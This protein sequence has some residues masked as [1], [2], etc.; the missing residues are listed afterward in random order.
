MSAFSDHIKEVVKLTLGSLNEEQDGIDFLQYRHPDLPLLVGFVQ[1]GPLNENGKIIARV[2]VPYHEG[3]KRCSY[4]LHHY[5]KGFRIPKR[6]IR[7]DRYLSQPERVSAEIQANVINPAIP[8]A[9]K[10]TKALADAYAVSQDQRNTAQQIC[11]ILG[12]A[13]PSQNSSSETVY[14]DLFGVSDHGYGQFQIRDSGY[15]E[16]TM[17]S[18]SSALAVDLARAFQQVRKK[19]DKR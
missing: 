9:I 19:H 3:P 2:S 10:A 6:A 11:K 7:A 1:Q 13:N 5:M 17:Q 4:L 18:L 12:K 15:I 16:L 14:I 8:A